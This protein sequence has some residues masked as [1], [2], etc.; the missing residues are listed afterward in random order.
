M[1]RRAAVWLVLIV[2][3]TAHNVL[4][5]EPSAATAI[6]DL[7]AA[8]TCTTPRRGGLN[9]GA[10]LLFLAP[11]F[12]SNPAYFLTT[13]SVSG[14][15]LPPTTTQR[16]QEF[17]YDLQP[18][19]RL[20][21][22]YALDGG[23]GARVRWFRFDHSAE[24]LNASNPAIPLGSPVVFRSLASTSP[25]MAITQQIQLPAVNAIQTPA[26]MG[27]DQQ[28]RFTSDLLL[29]VW[30][31]EAVYS[32]I[33]TGLWNFELFGGL[34]YARIEQ[35]YGAVAAGFVPQFLISEQTFNGAGPT[36]G[37]EGRRRLGDTNFGFYGLGRLSL[38]FGE[39]THN[40]RGLNIGLVPPFTYAFH[41]NS[42]SRD[43]ILPMIELE[44]GVEGTR[45]I[46]PVDWLLRTGIVSQ[47]LPIGSGANGNGNAGLIGLS[48]ATGF[49]Y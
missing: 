24:S 41:D 21:L 1:H 37:L 10:E 34:R 48:V 12:E 13:T 9:A 2:L 46:G 18:A 38:L 44:M 11:R 4:A 14:G 19:S 29:D 20:W 47:L 31:F 43:R 36:F 17:S 16:V 39:D 15:G 7:D 26:P 8:G 27:V 28:L 40:S 22:G 23:F 3:A 5:Q 30:D 42:S 6:H 45:T 49:R 25:L 35:N 33:Q 32:D